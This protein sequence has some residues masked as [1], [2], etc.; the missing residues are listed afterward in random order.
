M[1][2]SLFKQG[3]SGP[4]DCHADS[5]SGFKFSTMFDKIV[6]RFLFRMTRERTDFKGRDSKVWT[7]KGWAE[8]Q[9]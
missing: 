8:N 9:N 3:T 1:F 2:S 7:I 4:A 6:F 5:L